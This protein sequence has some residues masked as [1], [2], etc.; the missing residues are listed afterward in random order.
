M[1]EVKGFL[2]DLQ[3][4][5][6]QRDGATLLQNVSCRRAVENIENRPND[7]SDYLELQI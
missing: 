4:E 3:G 2:V 7:N 1:T 6:L 5:N